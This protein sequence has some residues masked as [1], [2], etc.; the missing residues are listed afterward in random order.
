VSKSH[1]SKLKFAV[2][3]LGGSDYNVDFCRAA[4]DINGAWRLHTPCV[5]VHYLILVFRVLF[6]VLIFCFCFCFCFCVFLFGCTSSSRWMCFVPLK[7]M[8]CHRE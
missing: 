4:K 6:F 3:G 5:C 7:N 1:L 2:F 8:K